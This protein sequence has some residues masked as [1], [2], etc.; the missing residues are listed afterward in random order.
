M[1]FVHVLLNALEMKEKGYEVILII[2]GTATGKIDELFIPENPFA[3]LFAKVKNAGI[4]D[5]VCKAC[6]SK[7][8]TLDNA[9]S[10]NLPLCNEMSGHPSISRYMDERYEVLVF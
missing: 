2:E 7:M 9:Q 8:G 4:I 1:C 6:S 3:G 5:C 10:Q